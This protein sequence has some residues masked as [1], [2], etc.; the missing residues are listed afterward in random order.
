MEVQRTQNNQNNFEKKNNKVRVL[1]DLKSYNTA[2]LTKKCG[3]G[4]KRD[5]YINGTE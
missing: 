1:P 3:I 5:K 2:I 4:L